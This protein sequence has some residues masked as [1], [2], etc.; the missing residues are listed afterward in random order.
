MMDDAS[1]VYG[2][3]VWRP[4]GIENA[5]SICPIRLVQSP[6]GCSPQ[7]NKYHLFP[8]RICVVLATVATTQA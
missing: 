4:C 2:G 5:L 6:T 8:A 7:R 1:T 3:R